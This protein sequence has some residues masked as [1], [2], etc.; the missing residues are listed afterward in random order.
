MI[1]W[2]WYYL[3]IYIYIGEYP[4]HL[5]GIL[6]KQPVGTTQ[7][8]EDCQVVTA[9]A[10]DDLPAWGVKWVKHQIYRDIDGYN[11]WT[12]IVLTVAL[13][14]SCLDVCV[15]FGVFCLFSGIDEWWPKK[16]CTNSDK[17]IMT[18]TSSNYNH[19]TYTYIIQ[20]NIS[21]KILHYSDA[22]LM[23]A[24]GEW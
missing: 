20:A 24:Y 18:S 4:N 17:W 8:F 21:V 23:F 11:W 2:G 9:A 12:S 10:S 7:G 6:I 14:S 1:F 19:Y 5:R 13:F 16:L 22:Y 15:C 3:Y